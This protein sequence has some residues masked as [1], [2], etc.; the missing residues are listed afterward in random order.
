METTIFWWMR[1]SGFRVGYIG[2]MEDEME[3]TILGGI[4]YRGYLGIMENG[5]E[6]AIWG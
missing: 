6:T 3:T 5:M 1:G 2:V 4:K